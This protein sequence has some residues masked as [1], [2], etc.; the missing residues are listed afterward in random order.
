MTSVVDREILESE[1]DQ[2]AIVSSS[3]RKIDGQEEDFSVSKSAIV[4]LLGSK[5]MKLPNYHNV[6]LIATPSL[7]NTL[8]CSSKNPSRD[9]CVNKISTISTCNNCDKLQD[10][11][12]ILSDAPSSVKYT[13]PSPRANTS[14]D[15][16]KSVI[17]H[18]ERHSDR[19][20]FSCNLDSLY[21]GIKILDS[22]LACRSPNVS[23]KHQQSVT[24]I[25]F[26]TPKHESTC[27]LITSLQQTRRERYMRA[28][29]WCSSEDASSN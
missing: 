12:E 15:T 19:Q 27:N 17:G 4:K 29:T 6:N 23:H 24:V 22:Y 2:K 5:L 26:G 7:C 11:F 21:E 8:P 10:N 13:S 25:L 20:H 14:N 16:P 18:R 1:C 28:R 3:A 9:S